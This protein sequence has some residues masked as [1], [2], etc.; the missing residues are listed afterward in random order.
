[1]YITILAECLERNRT[2]SVV[3]EGGTLTLY[4]FRDLPV[5]RFVWPLIKNSYYKGYSAT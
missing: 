5:N 1:M 2:G 3:A 4:L